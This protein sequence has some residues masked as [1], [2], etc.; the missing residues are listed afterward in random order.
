MHSERTKPV[1]RRRGTLQ[2]PLRVCNPTMGSSLIQSEVKENRRRR[3]RRF[4]GGI[5]PSHGGT[6][7]VAGVQGPRRLRRGRAGR[8]V[9]LNLNADGV[10]RRGTGGADQ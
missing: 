2:A 9:A 4:D 3:I 6:G 7:R 8:R 5:V 10:V 1:A